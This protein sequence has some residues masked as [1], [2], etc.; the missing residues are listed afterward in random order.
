VIP[1]LTPARV[2]ILQGRPS[3]Q[4]NIDVAAT[5]RRLATD[6]RVDQLRP[7]KPFRPPRARRRATSRVDRGHGACERIETVRSRSRQTAA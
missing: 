2:R 5:P 7:R 4:P 1:L 3:R 6:A